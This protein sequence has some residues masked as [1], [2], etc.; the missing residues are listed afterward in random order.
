[1]KIT[2]VQEDVE[3]PGACALL[4]RMGVGVGDASLWKVIQWSSTNHTQGLPI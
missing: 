3:K 2:S 1:M 4:V